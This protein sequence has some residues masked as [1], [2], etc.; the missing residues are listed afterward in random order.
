MRIPRIL[1]TASVAALALIAVALGTLTG[2]ALGAGTPTTA[3][4]A[5]AHPAHIH[6]GSCAKLGDVVYPLTDVTAPTTKATP[7]A[8]KAE[9]VAASTTKVT[10]KLADL[11]KGPFAINVHASKDKIQNYIAC[12]DITGAIK[13]GKLTIALKQL[14]KSGFEGDAVLTDNGDGTTTVVVELTKA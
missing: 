4:G 11:A 1:A 14:N 9:V 2:P 3:A 5:V 6:K 12:G 10:A 13:N 7:A 8:G